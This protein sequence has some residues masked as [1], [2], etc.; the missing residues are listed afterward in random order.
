[1][2]G[3]RIMKKLTSNSLLDGLKGFIVN[4][5]IKRKSKNAN[6]GTSLILI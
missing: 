3:S 5:R 4:K 2:L 6:S 1:M